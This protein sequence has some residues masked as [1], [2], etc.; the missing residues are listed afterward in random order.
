MAAGLLAGFAKAFSSVSLKT[1][2]R[3]ALRKVSKGATRQA[4]TNT[5]RKVV[6][7]RKKDKDKRRKGR[8]L[9]QKLFK[10][11]NKSF[12]DKKPVSGGGRK[13]FLKT[14]L[15]SA[16][17]LSKADEVAAS[18]ENSLSYFK[19]ALDAINLVAV[20]ILSTIQSQ[21]I[22]KAAR[23]RRGRTPDRFLPT[24]KVGKSEKKEKLK[25]LGNVP[26]LNTIINFFKNIFLG[27]FILFIVKFLNAAVGLI[28]KVID[29]LQGVAK[30]FLAFMKFLAKPAEV[31]KSITD[32]FKNIGK[33]RDPLPPVEGS[34]PED[35]P[36]VKMFAEG[37]EP[38]VGE[39][40]LVGEEGPEL[41]QFGSKVNIF[42]TRE[43]IE[44]AETIN[45]MMRNNFEIINIIKDDLQLNLRG[46]NTEIRDAIDSGELPGLGGGGGGTNAITDVGK[47]V[48][49]PFREESEENPRES[50][51]G[52]I[53]SFKKMTDETTGSVK[54]GMKNLSDPTF[55]IKKLP[56]KQ[57]IDGISESAEQIEEIRIPVPQINNDTGSISIDKNK[58]RPIIVSEQIDSMADLLRQALY[59]E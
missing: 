47:A 44:A 16:S 19:K 8:D 46:I 30:T 51:V 13:M 58:T 45:N 39:P 53:D 23:N 1:A 15:I 5:A 10:Q 24:T 50:F 25:F 33:K 38:P 52:V 22:K 40:V 6:G 27:G 3:Q 12:L 17:S 28:K 18:K 11:G 9:A 29:S 42:N 34:L 55:F 57:I 54:K 2:G 20:G 32:L 4:V 35:I 49:S 41:V 36:D 56:I 26:G 43:T 14:N 7:R 48:T 21:N 59:Q 37:G 31:L